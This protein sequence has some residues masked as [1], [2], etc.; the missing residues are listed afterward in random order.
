MTLC[1]KLL[2][3]ILRGAGRVYGVQVSLV[4][5]ETRGIVA[6]GNEL[7][8]YAIIYV[9]YPY[10]GLYDAPL[11]ARLGDAGLLVRVLA[12]KNRDIKVVQIGVRLLA[13]LLS[14]SLITGQSKAGTSGC[15]HVEDNFPKCGSPGE[16]LEVCKA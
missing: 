14:H 9:P 2:R 5:K 6:R 7:K 4:L 8:W 16:C 13:D 10:P 15:L 3:L 12:V 11:L 1:G